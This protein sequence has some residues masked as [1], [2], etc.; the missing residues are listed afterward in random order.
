MV[1]TLRRC[2][3]VSVVILLCCVWYYSHYLLG[4]CWRGKATTADGWQMTA[5]WGAWLRS[6]SSLVRLCARR[7][8]CPRLW[9]LCVLFW[10]RCSHPRAGF[11]CDAAADMFT[12]LASD[13]QLL[14]DRIA[15]VTSTVARVKGM[16]WVGLATNGEASLCSASAN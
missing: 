8:V 15:G 11:L 13:M 5:A 7:S 12:A 16:R 2:V 14:D 9:Y 4:K 6:W 3:R 1:R 10:A